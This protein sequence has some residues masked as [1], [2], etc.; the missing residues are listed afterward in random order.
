MKFIATLIV[1]LSGNLCFAQADTTIK[2]YDKNNQATTVEHAVSYVVSV[3]EN[4]LHR[5]KKYDFVT[6]KLLQERNFTGNDIRKM[7]GTVKNYADGVVDNIMWYV[8]GK[9]TETIFYYRS[10]VKKSIIRVDSSSNILQET[11]WDTTGAE[12]P[13]YVVR[14]IPEFPGGAANWK[15]YC[16]KSISIP[17]NVQTGTYSIIVTFTIATDGSVTNIEAT[18]IKPGC[19][20]CTENAKSIITKSPKW[21]PAILNNEIVPFTQQQKITYKC[22]D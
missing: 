2:Y 4:A 1:L 3:T 8:D 5:E 22:I 21:K 9:E 20:Y 10:G 18:P 16:S 7:T 19:N 15:Q 12:I 13:N 17:Q 6:K 14:R 11:G